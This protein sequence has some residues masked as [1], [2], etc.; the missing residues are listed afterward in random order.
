MRVAPLYTAAMKVHLWVGTGDVEKPNT[1]RFE[2]LDE[3][4][5]WP[6]IRPKPP[7]SSTTRPRDFRRPRLSAERMCLTP[8]VWDDGSYVVACGT[9]MPFT[10]APNVTSV[11]DDTSTPVS[12]SGSPPGKW[13]EEG[14]ETASVEKEA[15]EDVLVTDT[16]RGA[17]VESKA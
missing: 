1:P 12:E 8:V 17:A 10:H 15:T 2:E 3:G 16:D 4:S 5:A 7:P 13:R 14:G 9:S 6:V 11:G